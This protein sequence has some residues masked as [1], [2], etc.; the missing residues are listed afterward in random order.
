MAKPFVN[1]NMDLIVFFYLKAPVYQVYQTSP[2]L[3]LSFLDGQGNAINV[4]AVQGNF[5]SSEDEEVSSL[6]SNI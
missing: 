3:Q 2:K 1:N 4:L 5:T 6:N